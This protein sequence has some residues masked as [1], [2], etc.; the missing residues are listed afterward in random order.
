MIRY[1]TVVMLVAVGILIAL[2]AFPIHQTQARSQAPQA[3]DHPIVPSDAVD[4]KV[5]PELIKDKDAYRLFFLVASTRDDSPQELARQRALLGFLNLDEKSLLAVNV[6]LKNFQA[7][8]DQTVQDFNGHSSES[9]S[10]RLRPFI[11]QRDGIVAQ[12][13]TQLES[14]LGDKSV[15]FNAFIQTQKQFMV[16]GLADSGSEN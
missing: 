16:V 7:M 2:S 12:T 4:G 3:H 9:Q 15:T 5:H 10:S 1:V 14:V 13:R 6:I 11:Q 8:H